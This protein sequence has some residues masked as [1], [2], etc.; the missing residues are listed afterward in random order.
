MAK[1]QYTRNRVHDIHMKEIIIRLDYTGVRDGMDLVKLFDK[2][3]P[4]IFKRSQDI[5][6]NEFSLSLRKDDLKDISESI[7]V[8]INVIQKEKIVRYIGMKNVACD[9]ILDISQYYLCMTIKCD[10][11]YDGLDNYVECFKGAIS[12]FGD[13]LPYFTPKRLGLRKIRVEDKP[14][15]NDFENT[16]EPFVFHIPKYSIDGA[17]SLKSEYSDYIEDLSNNIRFNIKRTIGRV[18]KQSQN[19]ESIA[20]LTTLDIDAYYKEEELRNINELLNKANLLEF[21][22]YKSCMREEYLHSIYR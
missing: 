9:V 6:N 11:N 21:E 13:S 19:S 7:N 17:N 1:E 8:P 2:R 15:I 20:Y 3:F 4:K 16:F 10:G 14:T 5:Y 12:V 22:I 18:K